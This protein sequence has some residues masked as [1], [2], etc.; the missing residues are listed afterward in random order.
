M[1]SI[2]AKS[3]SSVGAFFDDMVRLRVM[4]AGGDVQ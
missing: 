3:S 1:S 4:G 2:S